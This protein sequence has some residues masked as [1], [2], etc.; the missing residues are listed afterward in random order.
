MSRFR[1]RRG[2]RIEIYQHGPGDRVT[3][4][5]RGRYRGIGEI[6]HHYHSLFDRALEQS[7]LCIQAAIQ[8]RWPGEEGVRM[9][10]VFSG[11]PV[12]KGLGALH[13]CFSPAES[14]SPQQP[15]IPTGL[16]KK[17]RFSKTCT[18]KCQN[19]PRTPIPKENSL[20][21]PLFPPRTS[22]PKDFQKKQYC[23]REQL[24]FLDLRTKKQTCSR[25]QLR[26]TEPDL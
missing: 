23:S 19:R 22:I 5:Y 16:Q 13:A 6:G 2:R 20:K 4:R 12:P 24:R 21:Y 8:Y 26:K 11:T 15:R 17:H 9:Y 3:Y 7:Y 25:E 18:Q 14:I 10:Y 1:R